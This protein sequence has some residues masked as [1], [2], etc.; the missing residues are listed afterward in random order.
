MFT[1]VHSF[2]WF[3]SL[4]FFKSD[5]MQ[6]TSSEKRGKRKKVG[7]YLFVIFLL[8]SQQS[9]GHK[10]Q[11]NVN[12][13]KILSQN[14]FASVLSFQK[15]QDGKGRSDSGP[16]AGPFTCTWCTLQQYIFSLRGSLR[17]FFLISSQKR[18]SAN[19]YLQPDGGL[20]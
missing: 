7:F 16:I 19:C 18:K 5:L 4:F 2:E 10:T 6:N 3:C 12:Q 11:S 8:T 15:V 20:L 14:S 9:A 17:G 1:F 13:P